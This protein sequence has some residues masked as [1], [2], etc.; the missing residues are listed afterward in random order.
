MSIKNDEGNM[1]I[2]ISDYKKSM[3]IVLDQEGRD[4]LRNYLDDLEMVE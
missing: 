4:E 2:A 3:V 1:R